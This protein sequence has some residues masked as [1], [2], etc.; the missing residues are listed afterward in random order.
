[1]ETL[2]EIVPPWGSRGAFVAC[3]SNQISTT[4]RTALGNE[5]CLKPPGLGLVLS[6]TRQ[7]EVM[8]EGTVNNGILEFRPESDF[9]EVADWFIGNVCDDLGV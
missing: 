5:L 2:T 6:G 9:I 1:V 3:V 7:G 4:E 8:S